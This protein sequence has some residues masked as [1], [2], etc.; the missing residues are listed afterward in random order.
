MNIEKMMTP[1]L[2]AAAS[3]VKKDSHVA[4]VGTDHAY[5]PIWLVK[6]NIC[7]FAVAMDI[8]Y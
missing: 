1:R 3:F 4:D 6:R 7:P 2:F 5:I 8:N